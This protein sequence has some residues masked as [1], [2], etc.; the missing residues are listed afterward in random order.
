MQ[1]DAR[2][3]GSILCYEDPLKEGRATHY[4]ILAWRIP[5]ERRGWQVAVHRAAQSQTRLK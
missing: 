1:V 4:S 3:I 2:D 5:M